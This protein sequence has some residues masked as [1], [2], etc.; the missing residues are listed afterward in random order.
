MVAKARRAY[1]SLPLAP[2]FG[3]VCGLVVIVAIVLVPREALEDFLLASGVPSVFPA[4][5]PPLGPAARLGLTLMAAGAVGLVAW[6]LL[7]LAVGSRMLAFGRGAGAPDPSVPV[8]RRA[9]AHPDAPARRP[10]FANED[11]GTPFLEVHAAR[12]DAVPESLE[13][14]ADP[15]AEAAIP[16]EGL[17]IPKDLDMPLAAFDPEAIPVTPIRPEVPVAEVSAAPIQRP[18]LFEPGERFETFELTP[19]V[20]PEHDAVPLP[21]RR[22]PAAP[23]RDTETTIA[24]LLERLERGMAV[25]EQPQPVVEPDPEPDHE[26]DHEPILDAASESV[27]SIDQ[28]L[29]VLRQLAMRVG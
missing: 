25:R 13:A 21:V 12:D 27:R 20:R 11:L 18:Q 6:F 10:L 3:A 7:F 22:D 15:V 26:P 1:L 23:R 8:L 16:D 5:E 14:A 4:V 24:S 28:T 9:D 2:L 29:G 17:D 19:M